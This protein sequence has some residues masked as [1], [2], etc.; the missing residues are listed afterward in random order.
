MASKSP[1]QLE[2]IPNDPQ[3]HALPQARVSILDDHN[4]LL[5]S[6]ASWIASH[7]PDFTVTLTAT[8]WGDFVRCPSFPGD[9]VLMDYQLRHDGSIETRVRT[10]RAAGAKVL[11]ISSVDT[12]EARERSLNA[13]AIEFLTKGSSIS[14]VM[15]AARR[16]LNMATTETASP[17]RAAP[18]RTSVKLVTPKLSAGEREALMLYITGLSLAEVAAGMGVHFETAKTYIRRVREKYAKV[19]RGAGKRI[20]LI[21]RAAEDGYLN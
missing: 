17:D 11:V 15:D 2:I 9:I 13:G 10:C 19:G 5:D 8:A 21:R 4:L 20:D 1:A 16:A 18:P 12:A 14:V 3:A 7:A 6:M